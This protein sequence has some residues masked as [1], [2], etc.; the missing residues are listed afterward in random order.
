LAK[1]ARGAVVDVQSSMAVCG[2]V[3][4]LRP[5][6]ETSMGDFFV[7]AVAENAKVFRHSPAYD[8]LFR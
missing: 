5:P 8:L 3:Q 2:D 7:A 6:A 4:P 1:G